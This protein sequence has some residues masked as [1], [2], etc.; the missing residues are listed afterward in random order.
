MKEYALLAHYYHFS[1]WDIPKLPH[2][3]YLS[4]IKQ[5]HVQELEKSEEGREYLNKAYRYMNPRK[6]ADLSS[7]RNLV[8]YSSNQKGG[9]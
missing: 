1:H 8:G 7:I 5:A 9:E 4:Y 6:D 3:A 2:S